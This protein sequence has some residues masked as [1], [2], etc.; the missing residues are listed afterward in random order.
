[1]RS[2]HALSARIT[3][4]LACTL[5][6]ADGRSGQADYRVDA[7]ASRCFELM[8]ADDH[9]ASARCFVELV[10][11][12]PGWVYA[13]R[14]L[15]NA[16]IATERCGRQ[17]HALP[18]FERLADG[19]PRSDLVPHALHR[20][21]MSLQAQGRYEEAAARYEQL[22]EKAR[23]AQGRDALQNAVLLRAALEQDERAAACAERYLERYPDTLDCR[24]V[25][26]CM[27]RLHR[28]RGRPALA[29]AAFERFLADFRKG[30]A[31]AERIEAECG[32]GDALWGLGRRRDAAR[33]FQRALR[34][35]EAL[36]PSSRAAGADF[37]AE[38]AY[39]LAELEQCSGPA[40]AITG[41][42]EQIRRLVKQRLERF[43]A[44]EAAYTKVI[45]LKSPRF[46]IA[47]LLR[48]G[49]QTEQL[50]RDLR[51]AP[52]PPGLPAEMQP[53]YLRLLGET[54]TPLEDRAR[55]YH[56]QALRLAREGLWT[57]ERVE[58][59]IA[60]LIRLDPE[61]YGLAEILPRADSFSMELESALFDPSIADKAPAGS[62]AALAAAEYAKKD[63]DL[64]RVLRFL[65]Q[66]V[67]A[68]PQDDRLR[69]DLGVVQAE[70]GLHGRA[71]ESY[72]RALMLRP[73]DARPLVNLAALSFLQGDLE[74]ARA[75]LARAA[76]LD[77]ESALPRADLAVIA[78]VMGDPGSAL[79]QAREA[80]ARDGGSVLARRALV[81]A[82]RQQARWPLA[83]LACQEMLLASS[84]GRM[85]PEA[86]NLLGV[87]Q[88]GKGS[89]GRAM[90][91]FARAGEAEPGCLSA[92]LNLGALRLRLRDGKGA[93]A[94]F[95]EALRLQPGDPHALVWRACALRL[96]GRL[97]EAEAALVAIAAK[98]PYL[99]EARWNLAV[100]L[101][102]RRLPAASSAAQAAGLC[103]RAIEQLRFYTEHALP[104][105][106]ARIEEARRRIAACQAAVDQ[107]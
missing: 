3:V 96:Q 70:L 21:A 86:L 90:Q 17:R 12:Q 102:D 100:L 89:A 44:C 95:G 18:I 75:M 41:K 73:G 99:T 35:F 16:A 85:G 83:E 63:R 28:D 54:G 98:Q 103:R 87:V 58:R 65:Q 67:E 30:A 39:R 66:A 14:A 104:R 49:E 33:H 27:A 37:A 105:D 61:R 20:I 6:A 91:A 23:D 52:P 82:F 45:R 15:F 80:L 94:S 56:E 53:E 78:L 81:L 26:L 76:A 106:E 7:R 5:L 2:V 10:D 59:V 34:R 55:Q 42:P 19:Y 57:D 79:L 31:P 77:E 25:L 64:K 107:R 93:L 74:Q 68:R 47:A 101:Q 62:A 24:R 69:F 60:A 46:A 88:L 40:D 29:R 11:A 8:R 92:H 22:A 97:D 32:L 38:A 71:I 84:G 43:R 50:A 1:M 72:R 9:E 13:D 48:M 51:A 36:P 4:L